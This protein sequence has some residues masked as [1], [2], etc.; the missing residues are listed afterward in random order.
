MSRTY[1]Y[2]LELIEQFRI[3]TTTLRHSTSY[4]V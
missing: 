1:V 2:G 4:D 3:N